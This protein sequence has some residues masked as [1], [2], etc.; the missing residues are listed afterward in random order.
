MRL[1]NIKTLLYIQIILSGML[2]A[3]LY[4]MGFPTTGIFIVGVLFTAFTLATHMRAITLG[5]I[6]TANNDDLYKE[7]TKWHR[8]EETIRKKER[9]RHG[10]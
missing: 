5:M 7:L 4:H 1:I 10:K 6:E 2:F 8:L 3:Y 9:D